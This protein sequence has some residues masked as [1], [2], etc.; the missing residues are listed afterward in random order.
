[1]TTAGTDRIPNSRDRF[2]TAASFM[3]RTSTEHDPQTMLGLVVHLRAGLTNAEC[4]RALWLAGAR[5]LS[6]EVEGVRMEC[7]LSIAVT[8]TEM[9]VAFGDVRLLV[10][11]DGTGQ[12]FPRPRRFREV[13]GAAAVVWEVPR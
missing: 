5:R 10:R 9:L 13:E 7:K 8:I 12:L 1:M 2:A 4:F 11:G 6:V 3:S